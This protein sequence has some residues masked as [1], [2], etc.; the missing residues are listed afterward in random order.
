MISRLSLLIACLVGA[1]ATVHADEPANELEYSCKDLVVIGRVV[2]LSS[3][4]I[5]DSDFLPNWQSRNKLEV[6]IK[7][8]VRGS[9]RRNVV[10]AIGIH[11]GKLRDDLDFLAVLRPTETGV[12]RF[13]TAAVWNER[14]HPR[15]V[16][17]CS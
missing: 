1:C 11:H 4:G 16:E 15:L 7:R 8:V 2:T 5:P 12:Y 3:E 13:E 14:P 17:P 6:R 9:E 10:P